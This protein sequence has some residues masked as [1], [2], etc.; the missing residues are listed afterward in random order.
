MMSG[1]GGFSNFARNFHANIKY[2]AK[3][4]NTN[5]SEISSST[6]PPFLVLT[7]F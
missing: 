3:I 4:Q 6:P 7:K 1:I 2:D 5:K